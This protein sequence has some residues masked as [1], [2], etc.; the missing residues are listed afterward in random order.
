MSNGNNQRNSPE[1]IIFD[2]NLQEFASRIG[3]ICGLESG[4][5]IP[6]QEAY[7]RIKKLWKDLR[8]S[9]RNLLP[10]D[11]PD[12]LANPDPDSENQTDS[13]SESDDE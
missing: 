6:P 7:K 4:G 5:K 3:I 13:E 2:A 12:P 1:E 9:K 8:D 11:A 10:K